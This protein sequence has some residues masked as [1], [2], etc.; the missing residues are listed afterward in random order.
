MSLIGVCK[1][2]I[3]RYLI[4]FILCI[5]FFLPSCKEEISDNPFV[6]S[7]EGKQ[8]ERLYVY[9][10]FGDS[11]LSIYSN[12]DPTLKLRLKVDGTGTLKIDTGSSVGDVA[13]NW[14]YKEDEKQMILVMESE[15]YVDQGYINENTIRKFKI[16]DKFAEF[17]VW[18]DTEYIIGANTQDTVGVNYI[19]WELE[20]D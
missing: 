9:D 5:I 15:S 1:K 20:R 8:T 6:D 11:T 3:S 14:F 10:N 7:W 19:T 13:V 18:I 16:V 2:L 12:P 4:L 17:Q